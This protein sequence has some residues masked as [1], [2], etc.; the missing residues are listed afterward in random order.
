MQNNVPFVSCREHLKTDMADKALK[1]WT[2]PPNVFLVATSS[3]SPEKVLGCISYRQIAANTVEMH[4]L[5]VDT[6]ARGLG[7]GR[8]LV[9]AL[10]D[11]ARQN[12]YKMLYLETSSA[13]FD[14]IK[15]YDRMDF[16]SR[17]EKKFGV[18]LLDVLFAINKIAYT[19]RI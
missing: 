1:F 15:F 9:Q 12:G 14:A 4:R 8:K 16:D 3:S 17:Q 13:Q 2:T 18:F 19:F 7:I 11:T 5:S 6:H 10:V